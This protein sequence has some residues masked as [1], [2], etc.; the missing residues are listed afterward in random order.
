MG[1]L[2]ATCDGCD[3]V[4]AVEDAHRD[5]DD[6]Y[7]CEKCHLKRD[8]QELEDECANKWRWLKDTHLGDLFKKRHRLRDLKKQLEKLEV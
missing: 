5:Y 8:I 6:L 3:V 1:V 7:W 2:S 4:L